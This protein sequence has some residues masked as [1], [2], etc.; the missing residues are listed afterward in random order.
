M[1][2]LLFGLIM[3]MVITKPVISYAQDVNNQ[4]DMPVSIPVT[5]VEVNQETGEFQVDIVV[6]E[7]V[8]Y[9][10][11]EF[12]MVCAPECEITKVEYDKELSTTGPAENDLTWFGFFD[13]EDSFSESIIATVYGKCQTGTDS[14]IALKTVKKYTVGDKEYSEEDFTIDTKI[15]LLSDISI[16]EEETPLATLDNEQ[17]INAWVIIISCICAAG[18]IGALIYIGI[19]RKKRP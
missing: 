12:G 11:M 2:K 1:K 17:G 6:N 18:I 19:I 5:E 13:G 9:A 10:G 3:A 16:E 15:S 7:S 4:G 14:E 8:N